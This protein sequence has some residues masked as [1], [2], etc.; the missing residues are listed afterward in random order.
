[1]I[2]QIATVVD[3]EAL[4]DMVLA[5]VVSGL[6]IIII[7]SFALLGA[8][9]FAELGRVGRTNAAL[10][11]GVLAVGAALAFAAAIT[12]GIIVMTQK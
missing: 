3:I 5:A 8:A 7:F 4:L 1:M 6:G 2:S 10:A 12:A 9:R 11:Y